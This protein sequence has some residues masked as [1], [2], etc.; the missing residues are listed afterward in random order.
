[1]N[2][3]FKNIQFSCRQLTLE[4]GKKYEERERERERA[5]DKIE[6]NLT[7]ENFFLSKNNF[8]EISI[9]FELS[10][11]SFLQPVVG[12]KQLRFA[13]VVEWLAAP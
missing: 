7:L 1:M 12:V 8:L 11:F 10:F 4:K 2:L 13:D 6:A 3:V 9:K 5:F